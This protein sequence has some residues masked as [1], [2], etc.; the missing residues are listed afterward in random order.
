MQQQELMTR[1]DDATG[2]LKMSSDEE[3]EVARMSCCK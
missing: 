3:Q 1:S 2:M